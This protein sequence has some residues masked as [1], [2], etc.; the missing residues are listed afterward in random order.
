VFL[1]DYNNTT[2]FR[3]KFVSVVAS[4]TLHNIGDVS[5][6]NQVDMGTMGTWSESSK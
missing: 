3:I 6:Y 5:H 1:M 4:P 2:G